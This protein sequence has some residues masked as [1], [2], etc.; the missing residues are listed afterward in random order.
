M[1]SKAAMPASKSQMVW[2]RCIIKKFVTKLNEKDQN[3][4]P[5]AFCWIFTRYIPIAILL[6]K[7]AVVTGF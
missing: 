4:M 3:K 1:V 7:E 2:M 5:A 6:V